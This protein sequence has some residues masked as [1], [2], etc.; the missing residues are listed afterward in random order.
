MEEVE[1]LP[2][3]A[4]SIHLSKLGSHICSAYLEHIIHD[5][6]ED[7]PEFH[8][9]LIELYMVEVKK[10]EGQD[11]LRTSHVRFMAPLFSS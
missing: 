6:G 5:L 1:A 8:E 9:N 2:R 10:A 4:V 3:H 11:G 7:G